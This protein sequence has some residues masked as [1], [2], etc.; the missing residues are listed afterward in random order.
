MNFEVRTRA[1]KEHPQAVIFTLTGHLDAS[2]VG[3]LE[4]RLREQNQSGP[5]NW[6][7]DLS[8]LEYISSAGL[9]AFIGALPGLKANQGHLRFHSL[10]P[11]L[12]RIFQFMGLT[13]YFQIYPDEASALSQAGALPALDSVQG[14]QLMKPVGA[15]SA[16]SN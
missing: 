13:Q 2:T 5:W 12:E 6:V 11:K 3:I 14:I 8:G 4:D 9:G 1:D 15:K 10:P 7:A 16:G